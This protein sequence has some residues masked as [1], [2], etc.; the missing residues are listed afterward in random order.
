MDRYFSGEVADRD[1]PKLSPTIIMA[2]FFKL[3]LYGTWSH[4]HT[5]SDKFNLG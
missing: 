2:K 5:N 1:H 3:S 4:S